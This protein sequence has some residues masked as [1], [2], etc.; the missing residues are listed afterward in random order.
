M[1]NILLTTDSENILVFCDDDCELDCKTMAA[2]ALFDNIPINEVYEIKEEETQ[3][4]YYSPVWIR[5]TEKI[6]QSVKDKAKQWFE[7]A[8]E[9][10]LNRLN[11]ICGIYKTN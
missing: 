5:S 6:Y 3:Y 7:N 2:W 11:E 10:E 8:S 9:T 1:K 4:Y